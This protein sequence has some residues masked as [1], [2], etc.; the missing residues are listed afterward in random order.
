MHNS[1]KMGYGLRNV[2]IR[3]KLM[4]GQEA[5]IW[6]ESREGEGTSVYVT[7]PRIEHE[8]RGL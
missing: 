1:T 3:L 8:N 4:F 7:V 6:I 5:K 2:N